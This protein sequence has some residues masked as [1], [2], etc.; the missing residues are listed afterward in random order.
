[1][2][3]GYDKGEIW[4]DFVVKVWSKRKLVNEAG[5]ER[6]VA[7]KESARSSYSGGLVP[8]TRGARRSLVE[9]I[10]PNAKNVNGVAGQNFQALLSLLLGKCS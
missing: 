1:M 5:F 10:K 2:H 6:N 9:T 7:L 8:P 3:S 4:G